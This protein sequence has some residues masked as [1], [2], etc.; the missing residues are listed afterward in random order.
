MKSFNKLIGLM[1]H[2]KQNRTRKSN[3]THETNKNKEETGKNNYSK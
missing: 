1:P 3:R 2:R